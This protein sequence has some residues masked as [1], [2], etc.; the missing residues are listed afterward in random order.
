MTRERVPPHSVEGPSG[1]RNIGASG[2]CRAR[3]RQPGQ[4][5]DARLEIIGAIRKPAVG[6]RHG[7]F[8][9]HRLSRARLARIRRRDG[10]KERAG[11]AAAPAAGVA[12]FAAF[13]IA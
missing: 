2:G 13:A 3:E 6:Y 11:D 4:E 10:V 5:G 7:S 1:T 8:S 12:E 9:P